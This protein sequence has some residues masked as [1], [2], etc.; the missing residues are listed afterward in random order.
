M[1]LAACKLWVTLAAGWLGVL[2]AAAPRAAIAQAGAI[3]DAPV[4]SV[5]LPDAGSA[6]L[7]PASAWP[8]RAFRTSRDEIQGVIVPWEVPVSRLIPAFTSGF[9]DVRADLVTEDRSALD[10][11]QKGTLVLEGPRGLIFRLGSAEEAKQKGFLRGPSRGAGPD[12][13]IVFR[14]VSAEAQPGDGPGQATCAVAIQRTWFAYYDPIL[15]RPGRK[16][17]GKPVGGAGDDPPNEAVVARGVVLVMPGLYGTPE[18]IFDLMVKQFRQSGWG[19]LRMLAQPSR[20][21]QRVRIEVDPEDLETGA[22]AVSTVLCDR[23]AECA[24]ASQAAWKYLEEKHPELKGLPKSV[25]G[26]SG[27]GMTLPT[28]VAREPERYAACVMIGAAADYWLIARRSSYRGDASSVDVRVK[29]AEG[30]A[31]EA[32]P[33]IDWRR[34]DQLYLASSPLDPFHCARLMQ[35]KRV[36]MLHGQADTAVPAN[37]GDVLWERLGRPE[38]WE[39]PTGHEGLIIEMVPRD[40]EKLIAWLKAAGMG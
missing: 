14:F 2:M 33:A 32:D 13:A 40:M 26:V 15:P 6:F 19:V 16:S 25:V 37:L 9:E 11:A 34:F 35:G 1:R 4:S 5:F 36:L 38:R 20:F 23:A 30:P 27:G 7:D 29:G 39:Y 24:L 12:A 8:V 31:G 10:P 3:S 17:A 28:V 22:A 18:P 21:T